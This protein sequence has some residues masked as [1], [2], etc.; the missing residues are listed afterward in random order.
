[1]KT[2]EI[3]VTDA[4]HRAA[5]RTMVEP[6][7]RHVDIL[8]ECSNIPPIDGAVPQANDY[9][10]LGKPEYSRRSWSQ[11]ASVLAIVLVSL[12]LIACAVYGLRALYGAKFL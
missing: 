12:T 1:M 5:T 8:L 2:R 7:Q 9:Y 4:A 10:S 11:A 3:H 6:D